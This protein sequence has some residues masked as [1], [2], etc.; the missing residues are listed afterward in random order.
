MKSEI[1]SLHY[2]V[3]P[4][5]S[6]DYDKTPKIIEETDEF[7]LRMDKDQAV[8]K[9]KGHYSSLEEAK[10]VVEDYLERWKVIIGLEHDPGDLDFR[11]NAYEFELIHQDGKKSIASAYAA[12]IINFSEKMEVQLSR[13]K[14]PVRPD[15][16]KLSPDVI[17]MYERYKLYRKGK[18]SLTSMAYMCLT[19]LEASAR[20]YSEYNQNNNLRGKASHQYNIEY[21]VLNELGKLTVKGDELEARKV[22]KNGVLKPLTQKERD[23]IIRTIKVLIRRAG[24]W[25][26]DPSGKHSLITM[27]Q[28]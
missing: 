15:K 20:T 26:D 17:T 14:F 25:A 22:P 6:A 1:K 12:D 21:D 18:E 16:F 19:V 7:V 9:M 5:R 2:K 13:D 10:S 27:E 28:T 24:E 11:Y 4:G 23:W 3:I 8:F